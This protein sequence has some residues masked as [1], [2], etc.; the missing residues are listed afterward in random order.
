MKIPNTTKPRS[1]FAAPA[2]AM[3][4]SRHDRVRHHDGLDCTDKRCAAMY[5]RMLTFLGLKQLDADPDKQE[6]PN[7]LEEG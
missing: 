6:R 5:N 2:T 4:L 7:N 3:T 1:P